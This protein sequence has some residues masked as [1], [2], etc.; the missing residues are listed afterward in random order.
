MSYVDDN[1]SVCGC[2][3]ECGTLHA[4]RAL[5]TIVASKLVSLSV[6]RWGPAVAA[7]KALPR[8]RRGRGRDSAIHDRLCTCAVSLSLSFSISF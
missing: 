4:M 8:R 5:R 3:C 7:V 1:E 2:E 6:C